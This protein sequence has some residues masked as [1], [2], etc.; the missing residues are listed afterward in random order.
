MHLPEPLRQA[1]PSRYSWRL[2]AA[3]AV[4]LC[5]F[6]FAP[7]IA[8]EDRDVSREIL[9]FYYGW[10]GAPAVS[11]GWRHWKDVDP[12]GEHIENSAHY[13]AGGAYDSHDP[14]LLE[15]QVTQARAAGIT[16][17]IASWWGQGSFEDKGIT[18]MLAAAGRHNLSVTA[19]YEKVAG[20]DSTA[21]V[22]NAVA[23][24]DY[25]LSRYG[26]DKAWLR[27]DGKPVV[28]IYG[29]ALK[30]LSSAEWQE[31]TG[32]VR[33]DHPGG[34]AL[35]SDSL[36]RALLAPFDGGSTYNITGRTQH[37]SPEQVHDW[38]RTAYPKMVAAPGAGKISTVTVIPGYD[39]R[40]VG[41]PPPR[42]VTDR[43]GG[44]TYR[45]LWQEAIAA[46]PDW[47]LI[48]SWNEWHEG[49]EIEPSVEYGSLLLD[50]TREFAKEFLAGR[51]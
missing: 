33:R 5:I 9:A 48:T 24:L 31:V 25:L 21:R 39:D 46:K 35:V 42:P 43:W 8:R 45:V 38:A 51:Q 2:A 34:V 7:A 29:R 47:V 44:E 32:Q 37:K 17:F 1:C 41:R 22:K 11:S 28:F 4:A 3:F 14:A 50:E 26:G 15:R 36:D 40:A 12:A 13:P 23:D 20:D 27:A 18:P 30:A 10:Y 49:S 6:G 16:G 19:Y